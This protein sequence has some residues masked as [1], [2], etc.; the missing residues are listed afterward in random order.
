MLAGLRDAVK[1]ELEAKWCAKDTIKMKLRQ[2]L[3]KVMLSCVF[4]LNGLWEALA[5][6]DCELVEEKDDAPQ[7]Q[8]TTNRQRETTYLFDEIQDSQDDDDEAFSPIQQASQPRAEK[9]YSKTPQHPDVIVITHFSSLLTSLFF[10]REKSAAH[11]ALQLLSPHLR[12]LSRNLP[13]KPLI[14]LL[15]STS[16]VSSGPALATV[17][18]TSP[19]KQSQVDPTL[20]SIFNPPPSTGYSARRTK[21]NFGLIFT[22]LLDLHLLCTKVP[23]TRQDAERT[24]RQRPGDEIEMV[25]VVEVLLDE[26]GVW[27]G[28]TGSRPGRE[29]RWAAV[30]LERGRI[31]TAID[32]KEPQAKV[33]NTSDVRLAG[34]F[35]GRRV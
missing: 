23:K 30:K 5:D 21:P 20:R 34:G 35:G 8:R 33:P 15:N 13:S 16:A 32:E 9:P 25:W 11:A 10:H 29:Q 12:D 14:L 24:A 4:D 18:A 31:G 6:L 7:E 1:A 26:L 2:C 19:T 22:Q 28:N 27:E 17:A 3:E